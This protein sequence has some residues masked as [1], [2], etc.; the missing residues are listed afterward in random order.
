MIFLYETGPIRINIHSAL[1]VLMAWCFSTKASVSTALS[2]QTHVSSCSGVKACIP[3][4]GTPTKI[5]LLCPGS[6]CCSNFYNLCHLSIENGR[7]Y[8]YIFIF[9]QNISAMSRSNPLRPVTHKNPWTISALV[10][11]MTHRLF[12]TNPLPEPILTYRLL[13]PVVQTLWKFQWR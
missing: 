10:E 11:I 6:L 3:E 7:K 13:D 9:L 12:V 4:V 2:K 5:C 1:G 8:E